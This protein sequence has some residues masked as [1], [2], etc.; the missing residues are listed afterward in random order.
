MATG[1]SQYYPSLG[2]SAPQDGLLTPARY[3]ET[4][5]STPN[6]SVLEPQRKK[7]SIGLLSPLIILGGTLAAGA[8]AIGHHVFDA[9]LDA[10]PVAETWTQSGSSRIE[11]FFANAFKILFCFSAGVGLCQLSWYS[12]RHNPVTLADI[13]VLVG[14]PSLMIF[15]RVNLIMQT[16]TIIVMTTVILASPLITILAPSLHTQQAP[17]VSRTLTVPTLNIT[18]GETLN[19]LYISSFGGS[20]GIPTQTWDKTSLV[21]ILSAEPVGWDMPQGCSPECTY[22]I[23]YAAPAIRCSDLQPDQIDDGVSPTNRLV[24]RAFQ[25]P[26]SA[27][28]L[29]YDAQIT[30]S[31]YSSSPLNFTVQN[32]LLKGSEQYTWTLAY[33]PFASSTVADGQLINAAGSVCTFYNATYA[34]ATHYFNG[35]QETRVSVVEYHSPLNTTYSQG[36]PTVDLTAP[37]TRRNYHLLAMAD[38]I[39]SHLEGSVIIDG[40][41]STVSATT[42]MIQSNIFEPYNVDSL[43]LNQGQLYGLNTTAAAG[44]NVSQAL[45]D[46]VA[47]ITLGKPAVFTG[48]ASVTP[49]GF[50][51]LNT[52]TTTV[53]ASVILT[54]IV[55]VYERKTLIATYS[56][57]FVLLVLMS[58][59]G[60]FSLVKNGEASSNEFSRLLVALR[61]PELDPLADAVDGRPGAHNVDPNRVRLTLGETVLPGRG[62]AFV[63]GVARQRSTTTDIDE[64]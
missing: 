34:A 3:K 4:S 15:Q 20:Y 38:S 40:H 45:Q 28:L 1:E 29:G 60:M 2:F 7:R 11:I 16:P 13:D 43:T 32:N 26:P 33:L 58:G 46:L 49:T 59:I 63:F 52:G 10:R 35:T 64:K 47:N 22:N 55:Y 41:F 62:E 17:A 23:T 50:V 30:S 54:D 31:G 61:N 39:S 21:A 42:L 12:L 53:D 57:A 8:F 37:D 48:K 36:S 18:T 44:T 25:D 51:H 27:Y 56:A 14:P 19:D 5:G 6:V 9:H 24:E